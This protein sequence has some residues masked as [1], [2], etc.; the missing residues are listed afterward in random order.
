MLLKMAD[1]IKNEF[2]KI[3]SDRVY[4]ILIFFAPVI[5]MVILASIYKNEMLHELPVAIVD[6]D[7]SALS[8]KM[9]FLI[10]ASPQMENNYSCASVEEAENLMK[11]GKIQAGFVFPEDM[12]KNIKSGKL[13][14][15]TVLKNTINLVSGNVLF[16]DASTI[17]KTVSAGAAI[18]KMA[19]SGLAKGK[20]YAMANPVNVESNAMYNPNYSYEQF[21]VPGLAL[22]FI[23][24]SLMLCG[25]LSFNKVRFGDIPDFKSF[26]SRVIAHLG[27][28]F[29]FQAFILLFL[30]PFFDI[31]E[32]SNIVFT[33]FMFFIFSMASYFPGAAVSLFVDDLQSAAEYVMFFNTPAFIFSGLTFPV[34]SMPLL[35]RIFAEIIPLTH[36]MEVFLRFNFMGLSPDYY[37]G[38]MIKL[39]V[40]PIISLVLIAF[41]LSRIN[42]KTTEAVHVR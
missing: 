35:H 14:S 7:N 8:R 39:F 1:L 13:T 24:I 16:K 41:R 21:L 10:D 42:N 34:W 38:E 29:V 6:L 17:I 12:E 15:V 3:T 20:A 32:K 25:V 5:C 37:T 30:F 19:S 40:F 28:A 26:I 18:K 31:P 22:F 4:M 36:F 11:A 27:T 23:Q 2:R 33:L 9:A